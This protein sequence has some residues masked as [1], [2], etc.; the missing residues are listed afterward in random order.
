MMMEFVL[1]IGNDRHRKIKTHPAI[2]VAHLLLDGAY[3]PEKQSDER[4]KIAPPKNKRTNCPLAQRDL[5]VA[6]PGAR[7][8]NPC[9]KPKG[10]DSHA[11]V[12]NRAG[13]CLSQ[14]LHFSTTTAS[15]GVVCKSC[16]FVHKGKERRGLADEEPHVC[17]ELQSTHGNTFRFGRS[18]DRTNRKTWI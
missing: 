10:Y 6:V 11:T 13:Q 14:P 16:Q 8:L 18:N 5:A 7:G 3:F 1:C 2:D 9:P 12:H 4:E 15:S 17:Q